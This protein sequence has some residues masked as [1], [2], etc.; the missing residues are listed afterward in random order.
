MATLIPN[1]YRRSGMYYARFRL[2][3]ILHPHA[4]RIG[5][6]KDIRVSLN[7]YNAADAR[8]KIITLSKYF[9]N[10]IDKITSRIN[11]LNDS[12]VKSILIQTKAVI[13]KREFFMHLATINQ[14]NPALLAPYIRYTSERVDEHTIRL[15]AHKHI[16]TTSMDNAN[17]HTIDPYKGKYIEPANKAIFEQT[18]SGY[19]IYS[20]ASDP[21]EAAGEIA[22]LQAALGGGGGNGGGTKGLTLSQASQEYIN[23]MVKGRWKKPATADQGVTR[24]SKVVEFIGADKDIGHI[25]FEDI[26]RLESDIISRIDINSSCRGRKKADTTLAVSTAKAYISL[27]KQFFRWCYKKRYIKENVAEFLGDLVNSTTPR[28]KKL[29]P[30]ASFTN[31]DIEKIFGRY[32]FVNEDLKS[33]RKVLDSYFWAPLLGLFSG[34]RLNE[35]CQLKVEDIQQE[36]GIWFINSDDLSE[37][38]SSKNE[39]SKR[40]VPLHN[41]LIRIGFLTFWNERK[42]SDGTA[43]ILFRDLKWDKKN[44]WIKQ[45][46]RW[47]VGD[48]GTPGHLDL[49]GLRIREKKVFHSFRHTL[50]HRM[51]KLGVPATDIAAVVGHE[52]GLTTE[53]YGGDYELSTLK[54]IVDRLN[55]HVDL[56]HIHYEHFIDFQIADGK[57]NARRHVI[58]GKKARI[59]RASAKRAA[60]STR[61]NRSH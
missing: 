61:V 24:L 43:A 39:S 41:E 49:V 28:K 11:I 10:S 51:R 12:E 1:T 58:A 14:N 15:R 50:I 54:Q 3:K 53:H 23:L 38:Q 55:Y 25:K 42:R 21:S 60:S 45:T 30:Y 20:D 46:S 9:Y 17:T 16:P 5:F 37:S 48:S 59:H 33:T 22:A 57:P 31:D 26:E 27:A 47:F 4:E 13:N 19:R 34:M 29:N 56:S 32:L 40:R 8:H 36:D 35:I 7:T 6:P 44:Q 2:P 18:P 52:P